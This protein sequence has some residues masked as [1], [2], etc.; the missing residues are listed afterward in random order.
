MQAVNP[1]NSLCQQWI[2]KIEIAKRLKKERFGKYADEA[3]KF[4]DGNHNFMW[5]EDYFAQDRGGYLEGKDSSILP[6]FR[7]TVNRVFEA[8]ALFGPAL[9][10]RN[11]NVLV[12]PLIHDVVSMDTYAATI[13][14]EEGLEALR[15]APQIEL[16]LQQD[17]NLFY[18]A[19]HHL[20]TLQLARQIQAG[21]QSYVEDEQSKRRRREDNSAVLQKYINWLQYESDKKTEARMAID[22]A[23]VK[24]LSFLWVEMFTP[25]GSQVTYPKNTFVSC[26]DVVFDP[27]AEYWGDVQ[28][29]ARRRCLPVNIAEQM[30]DLEEGSLKHLG[31]VES[32]N[33]Q[34][35]A[36]GDKTLTHSIRHGKDQSHDLIEFWEVY[37]K[38]GMGH[39]LNGETVADVFDEV[40]WDVLGDFCYL[41]VAKN[42]PFPLNLPNETVNGFLLEEA[43]D[44][45]VFSRINWP[46]PTT[47]LDGGWP[48]SRLF[49]YGKSKETYPISLVKPGIG[50][51]RFINW[52][53]SFLADK[54]RAVCTDYLGV[55]KAAADD[56]RDQISSQS[57]PF[58]LIEISE[59]TGK[60]ISDL[61]S[62]IQAPSFHID[63]WRMVAEVTESFDKRIGLTELV[64]GMSSSQMRSATEAHL[65]ENQTNIRPDDMASKTED[66]LSHAA[67]NEM[68]AA[69]YFLR[70]DSVT[71]VVGEMGAM[72]WDNQI[73]TEDMES[74]V[75][76]YTYR[77]EAGSARK[78]NLAKKT[79]DLTNFMQYFSG[80][81][82]A[83]M[84]MGQF[85]LVN[86]LIKRW[87]E[88]T[89]NNV[90]EMMLQPPMP[91]EQGPSPEEV[92][93]QMEEE[94]HQQQLEHKEED[95]AQ[96][97]THAEEE[98]R[99]KM[100]A[101]GVQQAKERKSGRYQPAGKA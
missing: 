94:R 15:Q 42:I 75:R 86:G 17:P 4:F 55:L 59:I 44:D 27:D 76:D 32:A 62:F 41:A 77:I 12:T 28:W 84:Q 79:E 25:S 78:P 31:N 1:L 73:R 43:S 36:T 83:S 97:Q 64:Y 54:T 91:Q 65:R 68:R 35:T 20:Q 29:V 39:R 48:F 58:K 66:W 7:M 57:G 8:V 72:I 67:A 33:A 40:D 70:G 37:S 71:P 24:G 22:E 21:F 88:M 45:E 95:H 87:G 92:K 98:F 30:F 81:I 16:A 69:R 26:D 52:C 13:A 61:V 14:G 90:S 5:E 63:I 11:P 10:H 60:K 9:Y 23:I 74:I 38:N 93:M 85:N 80:P 18:Y 101:V 100:R 82:E 50:E 53:M 51:L 99:Q 19:P 34:G 89:Q 2:A 56:I 47:F 46:I 6:M 96:K 49:F 3:S